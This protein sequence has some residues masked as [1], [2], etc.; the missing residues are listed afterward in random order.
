M[1]NKKLSLALLSLLSF[2]V[3]GE[4]AVN[5]MDQSAC[6]LENNESYNQ[7]TCGRNSSYAYFK[8]GVGYYDMSCKFEKTEF[9][10]TETQFLGNPATTVENPNYKDGMGM[11]L[12]QDNNS[13]K[14][15]SLMGSFECGYNA[16][17]G[18]TPFLLGFFAGINLMNAQSQNI[19]VTFSYNTY[20]TVIADPLDID[21]IEEVSQ[22]FSSKIG[23][24]MSYNAGIS[25]G[26]RIGQRVVAFVKGG[27]TCLR[28]T[29]S[30]EK[31]ANTDQKNK[32]SSG[33]VPNYINGFTYGTGVDF[34]V[35]ERMSVGLEAFG[36]VYAEKNITLFSY[37]TNA[38]EATPNTAST[39][40]TSPSLQTLQASPMSINSW[41]IMATVKLNFLER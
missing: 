31:A 33:Y 9:L 23:T 5:P 36:N 11:S 18:S 8:I 13:C 35:T 29:C 30:K 3:H 10:N 12:A 20:D 38:G 34:F 24:V 4:E 7:D 22:D 19:P 6:A 26:L 15:Q 2:S 32:N 21:N 14:A 1:R 25:F 28:M 40:G 37:Q 27:W 41:G 39:F 16:A 17:L